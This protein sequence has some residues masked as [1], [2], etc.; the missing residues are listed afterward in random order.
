MTGHEIRAEFLKYFQSK[1]HEI[2]SSSP[3]LPGNDPTLLFTN[4]GMVPFKD[5]FLGNDTRGYSRAASSQ[6]C[7]RAGGKHND[8]EEVGRTARHHTFFEML[9]NFSFGDYFKEAAIEY[10]WE[11]ITEIL[12]LPKEA[13]W[14]TV[15]KDDDEARRIWGDRINVASDRILGLGDKDNFWSMGDTGPC[16]PCS[17]IHIDRGPGHGCGKSDCGVECECDRFMELWNLVF[18]QFNRDGSGKMTALPKPSIDTG[19]GLERL[20][21]VMQKVSGNY[22]TDLLKPIIDFISRLVERPYGVQKEEDFS[23]RVIADH[24]RAASFLIGDGILPS[25]EGR[26]YVLRRIIRRAL[27]HGKALG[28]D[29]P[30]L[31]QVSGSVVDLMK[32]PYPE[33]KERMNTI[34]RVIINEEERFIHTLDFGLKI[35]EDLIGELKAKGEKTIPGEEAFKLYDTYGFPLD[36]SEDIAR[37]QGLSIDRQGFESAMTVQKERARASWKGSGESA[38]GQVYHDLSKDLGPTVFAGYNKT[39]MT[40]ELKGIVL[41]GQEVESASPGDEVELFFSETPFYGESGGQSGDRGII[42]KN[43][44][45]VEIADAQKILPQLIVHKGKVIEGKIRKGETVS[46]QVDE[47]SRSSIASNHTATHLLHAALRQVLGD[48]VKQSGSL[49]AA[50]RLRFDFAHFAGITPREMDHIEEIVNDRILKNTPV[51]SEEMSIDQA[52]ETGAMALFGEKYGERVRVVFVSDFSTELC[53][54]THTRA[55]GDIGLFKIIHEGSVAAGVRRIEAITG[56]G[57]Y[58]HVKNMEKILSGVCHSM[59]VQPHE[60]VEK[61]GKVLEKNKELEQ[62]LRS[63]KEKAL[64]AKA[65]EDLASLVKTINGIPVLAQVLEGVDPGSLRNYIDATRN[66]LGSGLVV[67]GTAHNG[68]AALA[69]GVTKDLLDRLHAGNI[70]KEIAPIVDGSG[71]GK[72]DMAQAGGKSVEK[73]RE[74]IESVYGIVE[75]MAS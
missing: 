61:V 25:N 15:Y 69:A 35:L 72:A 59:K 50:D 28:Q 14:I 42:R 39:S 64:Q 55:T 5:I 27:R 2:V 62:T 66:K 38:V 20:A 26:G 23:L 29:K 16:G 49:V 58:A 7:V 31:Y 3:L 56:L 48:H 44:T 34:A 8:L 10:A 12:K 11:F 51:K 17:E 40:G 45:F 22:E 32:G 73:L 21:S 30:F 18:M 68:K 4:A 52:L 71:G 67:V 1:G 46:L 54:G 9:G 6:K 75:R 53:G 19:M 43:G 70:I 36:L 57:A 65:G 63:L 13:L 47:P 60:I 41:N 37:E 74:A 33:L 24:A